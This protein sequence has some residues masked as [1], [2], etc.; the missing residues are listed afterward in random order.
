[1]FKVSS[2]YSRASV[3]SMRSNAL[4]SK[5]HLVVSLIPWL[6]AHCEPAPRQL[7]LA[8][9]SPFHATGQT[10]RPAVLA[11]PSPGPHHHLRM[12]SNYWYAHRSI[13]RR[14][15]T[16]VGPHCGTRTVQR[17]LTWIHFNSDRE[18]ETYLLG[19][20]KVSVFETLRHLGLPGTINLSAF[21]RW[22]LNSTHRSISADRAL[23]GR[24]Q[25][26]NRALHISEISH[27]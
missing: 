14:W 2:G 4:A 9:L 11:C 12:R 15:G 19:V 26:L 7:T 5:S 16:T 8:C 17:A 27:V 13:V 6:L 23:T 22:I 25:W 10:A 21:V 18:A 20:V 3:G 1:M 24:G